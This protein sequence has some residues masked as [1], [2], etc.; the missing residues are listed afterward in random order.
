MSD[1]PPN[2]PEYSEIH[3]DTIMAIISDQGR[4]SGFADAAW[5]LE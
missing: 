5:R 3:S 1:L 4:I 2:S